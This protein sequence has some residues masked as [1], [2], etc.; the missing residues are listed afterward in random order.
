MDSPGTAY[1]NLTC[2]QNMVIS[3]TVQVKLE[4]FMICSGIEF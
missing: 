1:E 2:V 4:K 3:K